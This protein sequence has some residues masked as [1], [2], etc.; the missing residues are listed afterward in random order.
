MSKDIQFYLSKGMDQATAAYYASGRKKILSVTPNAD[1]TL[2]LGFD[3]GEKRL[4]DCRPFILDG[5]V[6][7]P[8]KVFETFKRVYLDEDGCVSWDIDPDIDSSVVW[9]N[10]LDLCPDSCYIDGQPIS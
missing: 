8:L 9:N 1:F 3:N 2:T 6:F 4:L 5:T 10:K 7:A